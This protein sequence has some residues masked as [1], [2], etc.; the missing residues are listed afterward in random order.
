MPIKDE[1]ILKAL[2]SAEQGI[3]Q[4][5]FFK[6]LKE[7]DIK[8]FVKKHPEEKMTFYKYAP[9]SQRLIETLHRMIYD[10]EIGGNT[11][12]INEVVNLFKLRYKEFS[13][14]N[15]SQA[16]QT[17]NDAL[18]KTGVIYYAN[19]YPDLVETIYKYSSAPKEQ[20]LQDAYGN[21]LVSHLRKEN[22]RIN[23]RTSLFNQL[24]KSFCEKND[25]KTIQNVN[26]KLTK[27]A[28][29]FKGD[30]SHRADKD[31]LKNMEN[32]LREAQKARYESMGGRDDYATYCLE[33]A[34]RVVEKLNNFKPN[35]KEFLRDTLVEHLKANNELAKARDQRFTGK[36]VA[37][38]KTAPVDNLSR[39]TYKLVEGLSESFN[40][41]KFQSSIKQDINKA[42]KDNNKLKSLEAKRDYNKKATHSIGEVIGHVIDKILGRT[43]NKLDVEISKVKSELTNFTKQYSKASYNPIGQ[44]MRKATEKKFYYS[45]DDE[46]KVKPGKA[47]SKST[48][49]SSSKSK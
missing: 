19:D 6:K 36:K 23:E 21:C 2:N 11:K 46:K 18:I 38:A 33:V 1:D 28:E 4:D 7:S 31:I 5:K 45:K 25:F 48:K 20:I 44:Y 40:D 24:Y 13:K 42:I 34:D 41:E 17:M 8:E 30:L 43:G 10:S 35:E 29:E 47:G 9:I 15:S 37:T 16:I 26:E 3:D 14:N 49:P 22:N 32:I 39:L 27:Q 12:E